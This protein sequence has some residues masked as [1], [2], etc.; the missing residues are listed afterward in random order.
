M[1]KFY[2]L[3][4]SLFFVTTA[5]SELTLSGYATATYFSESDYSLPT[6][7]VRVRA[8]DTLTDNVTLAVTLTTYGELLDEA[9]I[10]WQV[11]NGPNWKDGDFTY[12]LNV[13][14][15]G[16][17]NS[18]Y[19][20]VTDTPST[21]G[22]AM[23]PPGVYSLRLLKADLDMADGVQF[24]ARKKLNRE[25]LITIRAAVGTG[26]M[27][28]PDYTHKE[29]L[30]NTLGEVYKVKPVDNGAIDLSIE[31]SDEDSKF[32]FAHNEFPYT[33][34]V[35]GIPKLQQSFDRIGMSYDLEYMLIEAELAH[36]TVNWK[37][38]V[39]TTV[40]DESIDGASIVLRHPINDDYTVY[41]SFSNMKNVKNYTMQTSSV[42][43]TYAKPTY[44]IS[45][46]VMDGSGTMQPNQDNRGSQWSS[47]IFTFTKKF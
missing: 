37:N 46:E 6:S 41:T 33:S 5:H 17:V 1:S 30:G 15:Y 20:G 31:Y 11:P 7:M 3:L 43:I 26:I 24:I 29:L 14:R 25:D 27:S 2:A 34:N 19:N 42:G 47:V 32:Y 12:S 35:P 36:T 8:Y 23:L 22:L 39:D 9:M 40:N 16:R 10:N 18:L 13:G 28:T 38:N 44:T 4:I 21:A 45:L